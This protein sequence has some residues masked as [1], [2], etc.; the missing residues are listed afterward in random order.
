MSLK[1]KY[2]TVFLILAAFALIGSPPQAASAEDKPKVVFV[3]IDNITW[4]D[5]TK[6]NDPFI[7]AL[8]QNNPAALLNNRTYG[9]PSRPR[10]AISVG[11]GVRAN[12]LP[13]SVNGYNATE[14]FDGVKAG[15][16]LFVRTGKRA[17]PGNIVELGLPAIIA[18]NS[19][20][21]QEMVPGAM[22][23]LLNDN[24]F[25]AA[26]LGNSDTSFESDRESDNREIVSLAMNSSGIV[27]YGDV[28]KTVLVQ[29]PTVPYGIRANDTVYLKR[30]QELLGVAD[31]I[32][33]D[34]G[35]TTRADLYSTYVLE[36]RAERLRI[37]ALKRASAFLEQAM[38]VAGDDTIF[39]I[40]SLSPPGASAAPISGDEEQLTPVI[41]SGP[42]FESGSLT[43]AATRRAGIINNTDITMTILDIFGV[44]PH[45][46][47][48]GSKVTVTPKKM[49]VE[50]MNAFNASAVGIK[51][52]RRIAVLTFI[53]LQIA[54][55]VVAA[56]LLLY[57][58]KAN[59][60][61]IGFMKTLIL[62][63]MGFPLFTFFASKVQFLAVN[64]VLLT[65]SALAVSLSLAV[66]LAAL[67]VNKLFPLA[68]IG[69]AT[70]FT[71]LADVV[72]GANL[73]LNTI[74]GYDPI[75]GSRFFGIGNE[76]FSILLAS[77]LLTV[78]LMLERWK[79]GVALAA[80]AVVALTVLV[81]DGFP[82]YGADV[83]GIIAIIAA[84]TAMGLHV[85]EIKL[86]Y[87]TILPAGALIGLALFA[88][89]AY[90]FMDGSSTHMGR[91]IELI[92]GGGIS[93]ILTI[94]SRKLATNFM[95]LRYSTWSYFL[96]I[97]MVLT[98]ALSYRPV[99][100]LKKLFARHKGL[101]A[102]VTGAVVGS[103]VGFA[104]NDSGIL[105]PAIIMSYIF[106]SIAYLM[107]WERYDMNKQEL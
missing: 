103:T 14:A 105:I 73:Q 80:G 98:V 27:D 92:A 81:V 4:D 40:A 41:I 82:A 101:T 56:L 96:L 11:S 46:T 93:G 76:A 51:S 33:I 69:C 10:A 21:H 62:T 64:G 30:L 38:E 102:S 26:V 31:F 55:Y 39:I 3:L 60:R 53:Y 45:Y 59:K 79:R 17:K 84:F 66:V 1:R 100:L 48:V 99:G 52:A 47:M 67:K 12:A 6:A 42:G 72:L 29:D 54:L 24:G 5:I 35:D 94:A 107:L 104:V 61:Y 37:A 89:V 9:R 16:V 49:S 106:P 87:K 63:S 23:Q 19:Y 28:G 77:A 85:Q 86:N 65:I 18:D 44:T 95:V 13:G 36:A 2:L 7:N 22:G 25:K 78:G 20:I 50:R 91:T 70:M 32:A 88:F 83:G 58:R 15:D 71:I 43:S 75:R 68:V 57:V 34:F 8:V 90:D 97:I 74:F